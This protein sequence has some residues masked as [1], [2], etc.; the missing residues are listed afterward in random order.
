MVLDVDRDAS[1]YAADE[2]GLPAPTFIA[3][4]RQNGHG[5]LAYGI[6]TPVRPE[7]WNGRRALP[8]IWQTLSAP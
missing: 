8:T 1:W 2:D 6:A 4:N 5:H 3:I 7:H